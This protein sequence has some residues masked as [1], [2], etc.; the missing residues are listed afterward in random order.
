MGR[1]LKKYKENNKKVMF[2]A[3]V[4]K[5]QNIIDQSIETIDQ[6]AKKK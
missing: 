4:T 5:V 6:Q 3:R 1:K 2:P